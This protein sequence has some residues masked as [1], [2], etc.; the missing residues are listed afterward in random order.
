MFHQ[1]V[2]SLLLAFNLTPLGLTRSQAQSPEVPPGWEKAAACQIRFLL[3][4]DLKNQ[5]VRGIDSCYAEFRGGKMRL[6]ID[7][8][9]L[10]GGVFTRTESMLDFAEE[11]VIIDAKKVRI[12]TY[13]DG[14]TKSK[15]KF[16]AN[17]FVV[18]H[19]GQSRPT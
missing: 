8:S 4:K 16:F 17:V 9:S 2:S 11:T 15:R 1:I 5:H 6:S 12:I 3:P 13:K 10:G 7:S 19:E 18:L 14:Q